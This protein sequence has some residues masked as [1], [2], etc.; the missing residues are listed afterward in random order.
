LPDGLGSIVG[1]VG[2]AGALTGV[3]LAGLRDVVFAGD[4]FL[5]VAFLAAVFFA[6][7]GFDAAVLA[8]DFFADTFLATIGLLVAEMRLARE[9]KGYR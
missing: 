4:A 8:A 2:A 7:D 1:G 3:V 6:V 9:R 5:F